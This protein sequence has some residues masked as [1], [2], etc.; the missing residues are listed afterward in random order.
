MQLSYDQA[1]ALLGIYS[2]EMK[3]YVHPKTCTQMFI[4][5]LFVRGKNW[6]Q[7]RYILID[8]WL[9][10]LLYTYYRILLSNG[11]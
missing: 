10:K 1:I 11:N 7:P 4:A 8:G 5:T 9:S 3:T 6:N 2:K